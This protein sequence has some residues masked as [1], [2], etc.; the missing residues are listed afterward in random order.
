M[1]ACNMGGILKK[2][3]KKAA[4]GLLI[5]ALAAMML[6]GYTV[7]AAMTTSNS[8]ESKA[9]A[10]LTAYWNPADQFAGPGAETVGSKEEIGP[11][12]YAGG[13]AEV[14]D[15]EAS[16]QTGTQEGSS[17]EDQTD[18]E[19][20]VFG[21][22][23][24]PGV[25]AHKAEAKDAG[26]GTDAA[27]AAAGTTESSEPAVAGTAEGTETA[28]A[29]TSGGEATGTEGTEGTASD[30]GEEKAAPLVDPSLPMVALTFDDGPNAGPTGR[31][32]DCLEQN[33]ARATFFV[34]GERVSSNAAS[35]LRAHQLGC[36]IGNHTYGH[37]YI[38]KLSAEGLAS[39]LDSTNQA[40][41]SVTGVSPVLM[42]PPGGFYD[43]AS[44]SVVGGRGM[45]AI[46]WSIDTRDWQ[47]KDPQKTINEVLSKVKDGDIIL[48]HDLYSATADA[49]QV[50]IPELKAR[51]YQ[52]VTVSELAACRGGAAPG[53]IYSR[54]RPQ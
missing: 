12:I 16:A 42:R 36:E 24:G 33:G 43:S 44:L 29:G 40:V 30:S 26:A 35:I 39:Q 31:I 41:A 10:Q 19:G 47:H 8:M 51:G 20:L 5:S 7:S 25:S 38:T 22:N 46:M 23:G 48:M 52:L 13:S 6:P 15:T 4:A 21:V 2:Y 14:N 11:G 9:E 37:K 32:L 34:V 27:R 1:L 3:G 53:H 54:F 18:T 45:A 50:I 28:A 49:A 17:P